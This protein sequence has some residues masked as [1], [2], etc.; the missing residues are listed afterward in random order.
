MFTGS[1]SKNRMV[2]KHRL[3]GS[4]WQKRYCV[5]RDYVMYYYKSKAAA[6]QRGTILLPG[7]EIALCKNKDKEFDLTVENGRTYKV[8]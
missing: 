8:C 5:V 2:N 7:Y 4:K 1:L 6:E 3:F